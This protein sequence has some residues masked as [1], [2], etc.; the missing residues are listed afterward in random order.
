MSDEDKAYYKAKAKGGEVRIPKRP[1]ISTGGAGDSGGNRLTSHGVPV[2]IYEREQ[3][4]L[5]SEEENMRR[6]IG[7]M[8][9]S[10]S[11]TNGTCHK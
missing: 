10:I 2:E 1:G 3:R 5:K 11:L 9:Q 7:A 6:R 8:I 4:Q